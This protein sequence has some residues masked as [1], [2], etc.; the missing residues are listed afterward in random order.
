MV[1]H[2]FGGPQWAPKNLATL[3]TWVHFR[4]LVV[5]ALLFAG[6]L[7]CMA[8]PFVLVRDLAR[9]LHPPRWKWPK[10]LRNK[11]PAVFL[12][13][14]VLFS[15]ELFDLW[16]NPLGTGVL[17][18]LYFV[19]I[20]VVDISFERATFCKYVCPVGQ[21]NFLSSLLSPWEVAVR[22]PD[23]CANCRTKEC[24]LGTTAPRPEPSVD[25]QPLPILQRGCE[26]GLYLPRKSGNMDC[27]FCLDCAAACPHD[28]IGILSQMPAEHLTTSGVRSGIGAPERRRDLAALSVLFC[29]GAILNA[30]A[31]IQ[32]VYALES[33]V[34]T[35]LHWNVEWPILTLLFLFGLVI[36]PAVM[37]G[38]TASVCKA[39]THSPLHLSDI[40]CSYARSLVPMGF[41][42]W[43]AHY[44]FHFFTG[45]LTVIPVTQAAVA[46]TFGA[47]YLGRPAWQ[48]GGL[49][50][51]VVY[52]LE[53][54]FLGLGFIGSCL[55]VHGISHQ[56]SQQLAAK[57]G[58]PWYA[59]QVL[60]LLSA[61]WIMSQPMEMRG[62]FL[63]G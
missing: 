12:F 47:A 54:G 4:G 28:N 43:L 59:L 57:M 44:G 41:G 29:F 34:A 18:V 31:M 61:W 49:P 46:S 21:F 48:L 3:L 5:L 7:F 23:T 13:A 22:D 36:I 6:N 17:I 39:L 52:V 16:S 11:W 51:R 27:T 14:T 62:T 8:C 30:F 42:I 58:A 25:F 55:V 10:V 40:V 24:I 37:L 2:A 50:E 35:W 26:L 45:I 53:L 20:V 19:A 60:L 15:Y 1:A 38:T 56:V 33:Y 32:P 9:R 63:G